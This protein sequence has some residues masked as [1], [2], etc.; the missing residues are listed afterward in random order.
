[1]SQNSDYA[2]LEV[3]REPNNYNQ[4]WVALLHLIFTEVKVKRSRPRIYSSKS[5]KLFCKND[6]LV[7]DYLIISPLSILANRESGLSWASG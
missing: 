5:K 3:G 1:M 4:A 2:L 6:N 7:I